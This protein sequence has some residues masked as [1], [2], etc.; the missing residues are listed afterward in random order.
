PSHVAILRAFAHGELPTWERGSWAGWPLAVDPY[1]GLFY[2]LSSIYVAFGA[3]RGLGVTIALHAL[4]AGLGMLWLMR[5]RKLDWGAAL[6]AAVSLAFGTFMVDRIRHIIFAQMMA[7]LPLILVGVEGFIAERRA[8]WLVLAATATGMALVCG[9]L[10]L[11]PFVLIVVGAYVVP[12]LWAPSIDRVER[13][14]L[15]AWLVGAATLGGL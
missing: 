4:A 6:F 13:P 7:W 15:G 8:R 1:Y 3:V 12:R 2:P 10:P 9:A 5:R 14:R 11:A